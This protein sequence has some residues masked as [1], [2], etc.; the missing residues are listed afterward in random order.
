MAQKVLNAITAAGETTTHVVLVDDTGKEFRV[1]YTDGTGNLDYRPAGHGDY[2]PLASLSS[3][4]PGQGQYQ[5]KFVTGDLIR[6]TSTVATGR[7]II[8]TVE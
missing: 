8:D 4:I 3:V 5:Q 7:V 2:I 6:V 1:T